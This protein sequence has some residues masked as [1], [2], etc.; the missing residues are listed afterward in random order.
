MKYT[1]HWGSLNCTPASELQPDSL[2]SLLPL[3]SLTGMATICL[4]RHY[5]KRI[6]WFLKR[7]FKGRHFFDHWLRT[8]LLSSRMKSL[9]DSISVSITSRNIISLRFRAHFIWKK[10]MIRVQL[11]LAN[12]LSP[13]DD[14]APCFTL[15]AI[16]IVPSPSCN[17]ISNYKTI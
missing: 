7:Y 10:N 8:W 6:I 12:I 4:D 9:L 2:L 11:V 15:M 1:E 16:K 17:I 5:L 14:F 3:F 13:Y